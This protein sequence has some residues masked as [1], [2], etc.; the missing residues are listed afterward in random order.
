MLMRGFVQK[1]EFLKVK[2]S[3][4]DEQQK[5]IDAVMKKDFC[6]CVAPPGFGKTFIGSKIIELRG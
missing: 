3:P 5:V 2:F 6:L 4:R 1:E